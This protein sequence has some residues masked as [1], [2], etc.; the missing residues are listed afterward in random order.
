MGDKQYLKL[1]MHDISPKSA[2]KSHK[3]NEKQ[4]THP[5]SPSLRAFAFGLRDRNKQPNMYDEKKEKTS[6]QEF[7]FSKDDCSFHTSDFSSDCDNTN[8]PK[9]LKSFS[10]K[11]ASKLGKGKAFEKESGYDYF[12]SKKKF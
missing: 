2:K 10:K 3:K 1:F 8:F 5:I 9:K 11:K 12:V 6:V 7:V 4:A